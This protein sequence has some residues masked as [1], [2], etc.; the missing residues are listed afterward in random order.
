MN[1]SNLQA[2][3]SAMQDTMRRIE[4][5]VASG[6]IPPD[7]MEDFKRAVDDARMRIW[8]VLTAA[9]TEDPQGF[10]QRFRLRRAIEICRSVVRDVSDGT[11]SDDSEELVELKK[12]SRQ[13]AA[14]TPGK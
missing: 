7:G 4:Q 2:R 3:L 12:V 10:M 13:L 11:M 6:A 1:A 8:A 14:A 9:N 5:E